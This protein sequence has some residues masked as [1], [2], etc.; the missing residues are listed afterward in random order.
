MWLN[1]TMVIFCMNHQFSE[2]GLG[3][4]WCKQ[5]EDAL[6][7]T[8]GLA[9]TAAWTLTTQKQGGV[10]CIGPQLARSKPYACPSL[11]P[12]WMTLQCIQPPPHTTSPPW[13][14]QSPVQGWPCVRAAMLACFWQRWPM[15]RFCLLQGA[16]RR[17]DTCRPLPDN[18]SH[19]PG[20]CYEAHS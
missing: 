20:I 4:G 3:M 9:P 11:W 14:W 18:A 17:K 7:C 16:N 13:I 15:D 19:Q 5:I 8:Q 10:K 12:I 2:K 6:S 1:N